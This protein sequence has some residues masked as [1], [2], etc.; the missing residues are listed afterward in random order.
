[1]KYFVFCIHN[2][3][4]VGNFPDVIEEA[5]QHSYRPFLEALGRHPAVKLTLHNTGF[6]LDWIASEHPEYMELLRT[7]VERGQVEVMGGGYYEPILTVIPARDRVAQVNMMSDRIEE[8]C[9]ARPRGIWLAERVWEPTLP[10]VLRECGIE[11]LVVDDYHFRKA[12]LTPAELG[13]YYVTE[14]QGNVVKIFPGSERLRYIIPFRPASEFVDHV[15]GL[16]DF[17]VKG[18]AAIYG[19]DGEKF[20]VW[21][22]TYKWVF[23][24]G[25][26]DDFLDLVEN[27][28]E[29]RIIE[30][31]TMAE[32]TDTHAPLGRIYLPTTSYMEMGEWTLPA[33]A[34]REYSELHKE[35]GHGA[36]GGEGER[37][38]RF[39]QGGT[40]RNFFSKYPESNRMHK[41]ML[42]VSRELEQRRPA[43]TDD[44][45][46]EE[47]ARHLYR[48]QCNDAYW[49]GIFGGLYMPHLRT[50]VYEHLL[51]AERALGGS[52][53]G[54]RPESAETV[55]FD[56]DGV[57]DVVVRSAD[58][59]MILKPS[60]GGALFELDYL[61]RAVNLSNT[62]TRW[63]EGYHHR[64][65]EGRAELVGEE[66]KSIHDIVLVKEEGLEEYLKYDTVE[67]ASFRDRFLAVDETLD[68]F[69]DGTHRSLGGF[70]S[71]TYHKEIA[72]STV[73]LAREGAAAGMDFSV[74]KT[75]RPSGDGCFTVDY[76]VRRSN[77]V[78]VAPVN[79]AVELNLLLPCCEGPVCHYRFTPE[80]DTPIGLG[81]RGVLGGVE[82]VAMVD[83]LTGVEVEIRTMYRPTLWRFPVH[84]VSLSEAGFEK[85]YQGSCLVFLYPM[86]EETDELSFRIDVGVRS[87]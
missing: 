16:D 47:A 40:W 48:A 84:T 71:G 81:S 28:V 38:E 56:A 11:Y 35:L 61:P 87:I 70:H 4:P 73:R 53:A 12:G 51:K 68:A 44:E 2:H 15:R 24:D 49:H 67:R 19:D 41:R 76:L 30:C 79:F 26:L 6:L 82:G 62:L 64:L 13:G 80:A 18:D 46:I 55:D 83:T 63:K 32:Y 74:T 42:M 52:F 65:A 25:W 21:P 59:A 66:A 17:L 1:M 75:V 29:E 50:S 58:L 8:L 39:L 7:M 86:G 27:A 57:D 31:E 33:D 69:Y 14:D 9:G 20:G 43:A 72:G 10:T 34:S 45:K 60:D 37:I 23:E 54:G 22:G 78:N 36:E 5:F 3:Q 85:I 77:G